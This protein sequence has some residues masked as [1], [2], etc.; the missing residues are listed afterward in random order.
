MFLIKIGQVPH[1]CH[2]NASCALRYSVCH[3]NQNHQLI[4]T[5][6]KPCKWQEYDKPCP[7]PGGSATGENP[8]PYGYNKVVILL[9]CK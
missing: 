7:L 4:H 1:E 8:K 2:L 9:K 3:S 6:E 5:G